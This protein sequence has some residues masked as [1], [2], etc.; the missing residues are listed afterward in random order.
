M[1]R[2]FALLL[3]VGLIDGVVFSATSQA[4]EKDRESDEAV[5]AK[6]VPT[7][8]AHAFLGVAVESLP[9]VL[10]E[11]IEHLIGEDRGVLI[12]DVADNSPAKKAGLKPFDVVVSYN[13][14]RLYSAEQ[15]LKLVHHDLPGQEATLG[16]LRAG[17]IRDIKVTLGDLDTF[18]AAQQTPHRVR[19]PALDKP[20]RPNAEAVKEPTYGVFDAIALSRLDENRFRAEI[21][22]R[23]DEGKIQSRVF[24]G[25]PDEL[26]K[27]IEAEKHLP[28]K[29]REHLLQILR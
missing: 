7:D 29:E 14:Q 21:R 11:H 3:L 28:A 23:D 17:K 1:S 6:K 12:E 25:T 10:S 4:K 19:R 18:S 26:R 15:L 5:P 20:S 13:D 9:A 8:K 27:D 2:L 22:F 16:V 24:E